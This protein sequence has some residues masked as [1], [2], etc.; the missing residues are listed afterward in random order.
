MTVCVFIAA[1]SFFEEVIVDLRKKYTLNSL[2]EIIG[3]IKDILR[4]YHGHIMGGHNVPISDLLTNF[5]QA[6][7]T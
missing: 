7:G 2:V 1:K 5:S 4:T 3:H 6:A